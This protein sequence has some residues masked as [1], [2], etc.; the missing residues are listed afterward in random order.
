MTELSP[1][2]SVRDVQQAVEFYRDAFGAIEVGE[3]ATAPD[4][5]QVAILTVLGHHVGVATESV[6]LGTPSPQTAGVTTVRLSLEV[7]DPDAAQ[8]RAVAAGAVE[9]FP[10]ADQPYGYRQGR[11]IDPFGHHWLIGRP[12]GAVS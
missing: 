4:G 2:L 12:L 3:R 1:L 9:R 5:S 11:V 6:E 8:A 10:V 7:D